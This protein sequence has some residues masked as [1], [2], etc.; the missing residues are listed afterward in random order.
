[1]G[2]LRF[3]CIDLSLKNISLMFYRKLYLVAGGLILLPVLMGAFLPTVAGMPMAGGAIMIY[4]GLTGKR[5]YIEHGLRKI[6]KIDAMGLPRDKRDARIKR[7]GG[8][9][10]L[11]AGVATSFWVFIA[12][13]PI[14]VRAF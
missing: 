6:R 12:S 5:G 10:Y 11:T 8:V 4:C 9:S 3:I 2:L 1:M 13:L 14:L 7:A